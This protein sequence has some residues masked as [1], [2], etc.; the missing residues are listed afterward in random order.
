MGVPYVWVL[1]PMNKRAWS[2]T[3]VEGWREEKTG[4]SKPMILPSKSR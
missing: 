1:D 2:I 3:P 4:V